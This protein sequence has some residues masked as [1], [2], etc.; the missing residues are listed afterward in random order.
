EDPTERT[1]ARVLYDDHSL[2]IGVFC[3]DSEPGRIAANSMAHDGGGGGGSM[4]FGFGYHGPSISSDDIVR[5]LLDPFQDKRSAY[6]FFV[7]P[8]GARGEGLIYAGSSSLNWDGI[9]EAKSRRLENGWSTEIRIPFK[10]ISFR[11]G[12]SVWGLNIERTI[13][14]KQETNRLSGTT[15][16]SNFNNPNEAASLEGIEGI[17]Q[18]LGITFRPYGLIEAVKMPGDEIG[19]DLD[20]GFDLYKSFTPSLVGVASYNMDFA[21]TEVDERRINLTRFPLFFP[22]KRMFFLEGSEVFSFS[23]SISFTPFFS[24]RIGL[25]AGSQ[26][27][28]KFGAKLY[29][30]IGDTNLAVLDVQTGAFG[31]PAGVRIGGQNLL[32]ARVT[33]NIFDQSKV[34][35]IFTNG[36]QT[37]ER[38]SLAGFDFNYSSSKFLGDKNIMLAAWGVYNWNE[39]EEGRHQGFGFRADYPNDLWNVQT[40]YAYYGE[41]LDPGLGFMMRP[42]IQTAY[43]RVGFQPRPAKGIFSRFV[44]Q[45]LF[46]ASADY[47]W[48]LAGALETRRLSASPLG[49]RTPSGESFGLSVNATRD[50]L[51]FDFEVA[52]GV[53][54]P[55]GPYDFTSVRLNA[56]TAGHRPIVVDAGYNFGQFYSGHYDDVSL[57]LTLKFKGYATLALDANL[58]RGRLPEGDFSQNVFQLKAD[59]FLSPDLGLM[60]YIQYDDISDTLGW[61]ARLRWQIKPGNEIYLVYN[62]NWERVWDPM[63]R[64]I[65]LGERGVVKITLS[66]RP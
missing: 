10:T 24:R 38:N 40:V 4:G 59:I 60:N 62:K 9:W 20:G 16:D 47:Y 14:R 49:F 42:A 1:E 63:S 65:P 45:F 18:G 34:G 19:V 51:P 3:Y 66:I 43:G 12:L 7:N 46:D 28:V 32:A 5:I 41:A 17:K 37:G 29:G 55:A 58:V 26:V 64:F 11:P 25:Y 57:G 33:Q 21:E 39:Q 50:V 61:N 27:P 2:Y 23:S 44:R 56:G 31:D 48:D 30:K 52:E 36:S 35:L 8:R 13:A 6:L 15:R 54:I 22:E 53:V